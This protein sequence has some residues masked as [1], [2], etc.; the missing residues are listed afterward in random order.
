[1]EDLIVVGAGLA[2]LA[3]GAL[4]STGGQR[5]VVLDAHGGNGRAQTTERDGF[6]FNGGP[7]AL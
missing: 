2:G 6:V 4:A 1:M 3:A 5:V 7:R